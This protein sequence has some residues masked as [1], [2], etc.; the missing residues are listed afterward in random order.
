[1]TCRIFA[2]GMLVSLFA[3]A[4]WVV[5]ATYFCLAVSTTHAVSKLLVAYVTMY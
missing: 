4:V 1:M 2:F 5:I 3:A